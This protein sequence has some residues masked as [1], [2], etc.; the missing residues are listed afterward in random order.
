VPSAFINVS[1]GPPLEVVVKA[2]VS[3][4]GEYAALDSHAALDVRRVKPVPSV[5]IEQTSRLPLSTAQSNA[6]VCASGDQAG[7]PMN[8]TT[9]GT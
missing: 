9:F 7:C 6:I 8:P 5:L 4:S 2:M 1:V 3:P